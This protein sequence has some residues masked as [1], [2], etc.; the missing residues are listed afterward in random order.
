MMYV[1]GGFYHVQFVLI[2]VMTPM[3]NLNQTLEKRD[4]VNTRTDFISIDFSVINKCK[5]GEIYMRCL[6]GLLT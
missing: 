3:L 6:F 2:I 1:L 4:K 5:G